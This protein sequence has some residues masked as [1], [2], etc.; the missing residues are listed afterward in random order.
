MKQKK[1]EFIASKT[2]ASNVQDSE[3]FYESLSAKEFQ[4]YL[5]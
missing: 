1:I 5:K 4:N 3:S 2:D